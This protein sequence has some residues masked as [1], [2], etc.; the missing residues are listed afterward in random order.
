MNE[1]QAIDIIK[2]ALDL[3]VQKGNF[4][5]LNETLT[6]TEAFN[7]IAKHFEPKKDGSEN[8]AAN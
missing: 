6:I 5:N 3:G 1:K 7:V 2:A 8:N 4:Q